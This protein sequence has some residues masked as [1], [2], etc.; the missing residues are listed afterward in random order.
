MAD[1]ATAQTISEGLGAQGLRYVVGVLCVV[2]VSLF[3]WLM[4]IN[5]LRIDDR[6]RFET[7]LEALTNRVAAHLDKSTEATTLILAE[8]QRRGRGRLTTDP[9]FKLPAKTEGGGT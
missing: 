4:R 1:L 9:G 7:K 5:K 2:V 8:L 6:D 3:L